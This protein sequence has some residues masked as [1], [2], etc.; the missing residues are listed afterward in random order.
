MRHKCGEK[1]SIE[2]DNDDE[3]ISDDTC[4]SARSYDKIVPL[5]LVFL[6]M[7][8]KFN[9]PQVYTIFYTWGGGGLGV[10]VH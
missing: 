4:S 6:S 7:T 5:Q 8:V 2:F 1:G 10:P 3:D 9:Q